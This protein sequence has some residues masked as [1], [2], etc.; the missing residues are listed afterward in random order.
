MHHC[1]MIFNPIFKPR[2]MLSR[3]AAAQLCRT[4]RASGCP[5]ISWIQRSPVTLVKLPVIV[6]P[7]F[8]PIHLPHDAFDIISRV[9]S[10]PAMPSNDCRSETFVNVNFLCPSSC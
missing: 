7:V 10:S 8:I 2:A 5:S 9:G 6:L 4:P 1:C 3:D